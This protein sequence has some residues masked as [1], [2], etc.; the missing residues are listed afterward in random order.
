MQA[1]ASDELVGPEDEV[2]LREYTTRMMKQRKRI[3]EYEDEEELIELTQYK[4]MIIHFYKETFQKCKIMNE[5]LNKLATRMKDA[6]IGYIKVEN[7]QKMCKSLG[8]RTLPFVGF[9]K[10][11]HFVDELVGF[12]KLGNGESITDL[13]LEKYI[14]NSKF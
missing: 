10:D 14:I 4:R 7:A 1:N 11:G 12:E 13:E 8:I 3:V 6:D 2:F 9:F 5:A